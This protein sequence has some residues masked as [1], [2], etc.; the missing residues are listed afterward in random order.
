MVTNTRLK[1]SGFGVKCLKIFLFTVTILVVAAIISAFYMLPDKWVKWLVIV[2]AFSAAEFVL[3]WTG[4][5]A[6]YTTSVQLGIKTRV[7]GALFGMIPVLNIIF[8]VKI[9]KTV[10]KEVI[11]ERE[12]LRL[13]AAR[14]E[15]QICRTKYPILLVHGVFF[16]DYKFPGYWGRIPKELVCNGAEIY[17]GKQQSA[18]SVADSGRELAER[19]RDIV[20]EQ[21]CEKVNVIAHSKGGL[22]IRWAISE[23]G[24]A[25]MIASVTTINT[26]HGGCEFAD[27]LLNKIPVKIQQ[28]I[29]NTYN[30]T[31]RK[32]GDDNPDFMA[33]VKDLT[34]E[35]CVK[36]DRELG[37]PDN[38]FCQSVGSKLN[39]A[40]GGKFPLN[41][42]YNLVKYF[43]GP[44]DGLVS[45]KSFSW[46]EKYKF[47]TIN[48]NRGIS[49]GDMIDLNRENIE[50]FDVREF[51]V[52][53]VAQLKNMGL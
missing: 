32:L 24:A 10:S 35:A 37:V 29:E 30:K 2:L 5:I 25:D 28:K 38:I 52:D 14:Q 9:I 36:R 3:F 51:Y 15:Q 13:N 41:F 42:T 18:A 22:D 23:C 50:G 44:N 26:P 16:R 53:L 40:T 49:H 17:Y 48:G 43:D 31:M 20:E 19:I 46:G 12:K 39:K 11:F 47:L 4:I 6:V 21:G 7:L 33:A 45:E 27:Y 8:L 34:A 1:V